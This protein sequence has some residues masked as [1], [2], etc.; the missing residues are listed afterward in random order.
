MLSARGN[1]DY[2]GNPIN[3]DRDQVIGKR[4][5]TEL[6]VRIVTPAEGRTVANSAAVVG[7]SGH[8]LRGDGPGQS[9]HGYGNQT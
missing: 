2:T 3:R 4:P 8:P 9:G 1:R 6:T 5:V 7:A